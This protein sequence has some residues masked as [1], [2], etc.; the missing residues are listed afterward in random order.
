MIATTM[1]IDSRIAVGTLQRRSTRV[2]PPSVSHAGEDLQ[3]RGEGQAEAA[4]G[5]QL[6]VVEDELHQPGEEEDQAR[7]DR[8]PGQHRVALDE[9]VGRVD[10]G[11]EETLTA[12]TDIFAHRAKPD[13]PGLAGIS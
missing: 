6:P 9:P 8:R 10:D 11:V 3:R 13:Q 12:H 4:E 7:Q 2:T 5:V 1:V